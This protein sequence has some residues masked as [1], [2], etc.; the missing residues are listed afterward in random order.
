[1]SSIININRLNCE[2][3]QIIKYVKGDF[4]EPHYDSFDYSHNR[5]SQRIKTALILLKKAKI[6]GNT[7]FP[8]ID[9]SVDS[10]PGDILVFDN[11]FPG[12]A[13]LN[14][15]SFHGGEKVES[16]EKIILSLWFRDKIFKIS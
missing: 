12:T 11:C 15:G 14:P 5:N 10:E 8:H 4:Y 7:I 1:M 9:I 3:P 16:G 6:G 13:N 2:F